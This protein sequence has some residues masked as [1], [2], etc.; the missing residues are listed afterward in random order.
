MPCWGT[1]RTGIVLALYLQ[2]AL[3]LIGMA[4]AFSLGLCHMLEELPTKREGIFVMP[5][6]R[7]EILNSYWYRASSPF[8]LTLESAAGRRRWPVWELGEQEWERVALK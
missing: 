1:V 4:G 8:H 7:I 5:L 2:V 6:E 3:N